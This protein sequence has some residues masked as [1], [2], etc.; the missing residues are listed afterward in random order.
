MILANL[1]E[2]FIGLVYRRRWDSGDW[3]DR[4]QYEWTAG[5]LLIASV[6]LGGK[7][8]IAQPLQC[9]VPAQ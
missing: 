2:P 9:F 3:A 1:L 7:L 8:Y 5:A 4:C 6:F